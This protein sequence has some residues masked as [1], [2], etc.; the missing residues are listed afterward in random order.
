LEEH[1]DEILGVAR[2]VERRERAEHVL[3]RIIAIQSG[4]SGGLV[5]TTTDPQLARAIGEAIHE[6]YAGD[7]GYAYAKNENLLRVTW[8]R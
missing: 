2:N 4:A 3:K 1:R 6:A 8:R 7:F 5:V